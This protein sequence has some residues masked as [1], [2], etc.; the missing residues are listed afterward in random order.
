MEINVS[1][2]GNMTDNT[3]ITVVI[4]RFALSRIPWTFVGEVHFTSDY[5]AEP[6]SVGGRSDM[7]ESELQPQILGASHETS[8][9]RPWVSMCANLFPT[10][11]TRRIPQ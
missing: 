1:R 11:E 2:T 8:A 9:S 4:L 3:S 5:A 7:L 6:H 10:V